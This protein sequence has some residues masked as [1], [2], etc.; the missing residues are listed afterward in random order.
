MY[1]F[2]ANI[3]ELW[4]GFYLGSFSDY[5]YKAGL[6]TPV[7]LITL[8][9]PLVVLFIYYKPLDH[10]K[11]AKKWVWWVMALVLC[12]ITSGWSTYVSFWGIDEYL[13]EKKIQVSGIIGFNYLEFAGIVFLYTFVLCILFSLLWSRTVSTKCRRIPF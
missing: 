5:M 9:V 12:L 8:L 4:G 7:S 3:F 11:L 1:D 13:Y 6:Y 10:I 2:I